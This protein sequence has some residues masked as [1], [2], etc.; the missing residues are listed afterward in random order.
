MKRN[1]YAKLN[2]AGHIQDVY[3][4]VYLVANCLPFKD[5]IKGVAEE[6]QAPPPGKYLVRTAFISEGILRLYWEFKDF[7]LDELLRRANFPF[8]EEELLKVVLAKAED[9]IDEQ[10]DIFARG[11]GYRS[12]DRLATFTTSTT[13]AYSFEAGYAIALRDRIWAEFYP[14]MGKV[15][16]REI[17]L[18]NSAELLALLPDMSWPD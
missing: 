2:E 12:M 17:R 6:P 5:Y 1:Y 14:V 9:F 15:L 18:Q 4:E 10:L 13:A 8:T 11:K 16:N 7:T 3:D